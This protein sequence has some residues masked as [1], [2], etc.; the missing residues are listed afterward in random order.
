MKTSIFYPGLAAYLAE[1]TQEFEQIPATRQ[2]QLKEVSQY[3][4][5]KL[6]ANQLVQV[7]VI[8]THNSRRSHLG[9]IWLQIAAAFYHIQRFT[10]FSG[11]TESTAFHPN[12]VTA[13]QTA[14]IEIV[15]QSADE[16]PVYECRYGA[17]FPTI[18]A[19]S[20]VYTHAT[21]PTQS[22]AALMVCTQADQGCPIVTGAEA[23]FSLPY[24]D[25]KAYDNTAQQSEQY[26]ER[27]RQIAREMFFVMSQVF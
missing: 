23:R 10:S 24:Q 2:H 15:C 27:C 7:I 6:N 8:C 21:N 20:K 4:R 26:N 25:P 9:Q 13:L 16:N 5:Q 1:V 14:G 12:A 19:F 11:G 18:E 3:I 22:F 17:H